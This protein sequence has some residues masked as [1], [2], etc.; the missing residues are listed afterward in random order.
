MDRWIELDKI[1]LSTWMTRNSKKT[2]KKKMTPKKLSFSSSIRKELNTA[3]RRPSLIRPLS[4]DRS[5]RPE[6]DRLSSHWCTASDFKSNVIVHFSHLLELSILVEMSLLA[7]PRVV[8]CRDLNTQLNTLNVYIK[9]AVIIGTCFK[10]AKARHSSH[11]LSPTLP[12]SLNN[13]KLSIA[14]LDIHSLRNPD[15]SIGY[16]HDLFIGLENVL[17]DWGLKGWHWERLAFGLHQFQNGAS[18]GVSRDPL[19]GLNEPGNELWLS[20]E[21][22]CQFDF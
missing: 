7:T 16:V 22:S 18:F 1:S 14:H 21:L 8:V 12:W 15:A 11:L 19:R 10:G 2:L 3:L 13:P 6:I 5:S 20:R 4:L 17:C 9:N